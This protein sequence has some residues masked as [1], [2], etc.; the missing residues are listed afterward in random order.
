MEAFIVFGHGSEHLERARPVVP[1]DCMLV[2]TEECGIEGTLPPHIYEAIQNPAVGAFFADPVA[3]KAAIEALLRRRIRIYPAGTSYP[4]LSYTLINNDNPTGLEELEDMTVGPSGLWPIPSPPGSL[5]LDEDA[6]AESR[7]TVLAKEAGQTYAHSVYPPA[8]AAVPAETTLA[9]LLKRADLKVT[10]ETLFAAQPGIHYNFLCRSVAPLPGSE[11]LRATMQTHFPEV[12]KNLFR[13]AQAMHN[14]PGVIG[15]WLSRVNRNALHSS[16]KRALSKVSRIVRNVSV[17]RKASRS[18][19]G[20]R[21][22]ASEAGARKLMRLLST[23]NPPV[24]TVAELIDALNP[25]RIDQRDHHW[26]QTPLMIAAWNGHTAAV[27]ALLAR[28]AAIDAQDYDERRPLH[29]AALGGEVGTMS[30]LLAAGGNVTDRSVYGTTALHA[31]ASEMNGRTQEALSVLL[32]AGSDINARDG[33]GDTPLHN[34][35]GDGNRVAINM[36]V[37]AGADV[38]A[39]NSGGLTPLMRAA[40]AG[41]LAAVHYMRIQPGV[42]MGIR[43]SAG[44]TALGYAL[45]SKDQETVLELLNA[46]APVD[47]WDK[48]LAAARRFRMRRVVDGIAALRR[49]E[50]PAWSSR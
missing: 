5:T 9:D 2:V 49:G 8:A 21:R 4:A 45:K 46:G 12:A 20:T 11:G 19:S 15:N 35:A 36:L 16:Q 34:A 48:V 23:R 38:N 17:R 47:D 41:L 31:W 39:Q 25:G 7:Y 33:D 44:T 13:N 10:Q 42:D 27:V 37:A 6:V 40:K 50:D 24:E 32:D 28:G 22:A 1:A 30:A 43:S 18:S 26:G 29:Y 3:N 14:E